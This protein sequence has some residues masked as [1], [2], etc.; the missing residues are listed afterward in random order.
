MTA[1][2][3]GE[4][5][6]FGDFELDLGAY[7]LR[8]AGASVRLERR[9][10][11]LLI[12]LVQRRGQLVS[13]AEIVDRLWGKDVF[14]DVD[15]GVHTAARKIRQALGD[16]S[17]SPTFVETVPAKGYRFIAPVSVATAAAD[18]PVTSRRTHLLLGAAAIAVVAAGLGAWA[19]FGSAPATSPVT[20]AVLPFE[21]LSG[22]HE[23]D[24][25][26]SGLGAELISSLGQ[27]DPERLRVLARSSTA[28]YA[29]TSKPLAQVGAELGA[30]HLVESSVRVDGGRV[31]ITATLV[32][33]QDQVQIW[34]ATYDRAITGVLGLQSELSTAIA[35]QIR[36]RLSPER[37]AALS[38]R[39]TR[40]A[41]AYEAYL[42]ALAF[43][44]LRTPATNLRAAELYR[45]AVALDPGY[46]LAWAAMSQTIAASAVNG[47]APPLE[48]LPPARDAAQRAMRA[49]P[50]LAEAQ[51]AAG[52][53]RW[54]LEWDWTSAE[55]VVRKA[56]A[57]DP[58]YA[59]SYRTLGHA[60][61]QMGRHAE[62]MAAM[63]RARELDPQNPIAHA[64]SGQV[65]FQAR[66]YAAAAEHAQQALVIDPTF[67]IG[68]MVRGQARERLGD[69]S[70]ALDDLD[71]S[72]QFSAGN[73]KALSLRG[74]ILAR[75]GRA[76]AA[77]EVLR[78]LEER[79]RKGYVPPYAS[80]L[81]HAGME[82]PAAMFDALERAY[83]ARD[84]HLIY[85]PVDSKWD[86]YRHDPRFQALIARCGFLDT[87]PRTAR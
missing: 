11:D 42:R 38:R 24:Y 77:R 45:Q 82:E 36:L 52:Y 46:A 83:A 29:G 5:L 31:R 19:W 22:D 58:A 81:V 27:I 72:V 8:R 68:Y 86:P 28:P 15:T 84:V 69:L 3:R 13:R 56:I 67:W 14:V 18:P 76:S 37:V 71:K 6:R 23:Y 73:S 12:L 44:N 9:P 40:N 55:S 2:T 57:L 4:V 64:L 63:R 85:L 30:D 70:G 61:S 43:T 59:P 51:H 20:V 1:D 74:Y 53:V 16:S 50:D 39:H 10:M 25:L 7:E 60:L 62:A 33:G 54:L 80:A 21:N 49:D 35:E 32:R 65:A 87:T 48:V 26:A 34:S 78:A 75:A 41:A 47:D 79:A 66:N 17:E